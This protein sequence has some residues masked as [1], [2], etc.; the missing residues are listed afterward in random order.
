MQQDFDLLA[1]V[2][3]DLHTHSELVVSHSFVHVDGQS[4]RLLVHDV[5]FLVNEGVKCCRNLILSAIQVIGNRFDLLLY[6]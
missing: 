5:D 3:F 6:A 2:D 1:E 4:V